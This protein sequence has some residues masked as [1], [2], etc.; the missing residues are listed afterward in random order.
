MLTTNNIN[1]WFT[2]SQHFVKPLA[3]FHKLSGIHNDLLEAKAQ[4]CQKN[5]QVIP[6]NA[7]CTT[8]IG[9]FGAT[10]AV[11]D[12][13]T[14]TLIHSNVMLDHLGGRGQL[15]SRRL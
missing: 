5:T 11:R 8:Q 1:F 15:F 6:V 13:E 14:I 10:T 12:A 7:D 4:K 3:R 9:L 2:T